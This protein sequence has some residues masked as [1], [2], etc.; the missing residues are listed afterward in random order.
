MLIRDL[1]ERDIFR[2]IN[3]VVKAEQLDD[4]SVWQELDEFVVT[5]ELDV[6]LRKFFSIYLDAIDQPHDASVGGKIGVW[7]SGFFGSGKSHF[8]KVLSY[9]LRNRTHQYD[10]Q[11]RQAVEFFAKKIK[12]AMF[13]GDI[14]R[15]VATPADV[16]LFNIESKADRRTDR[17]AI[18]QVFLK[19][20]NEMQGYSGDH[21][22][23]AHMERYLDGK[24]KLRQFQDAY[25]AATGSDWLQERDAYQF[26]RDEVAKALSETLGQSLQAAE[27]WIDGAED[28]FALTVE[29]F[30]K[31]V[32]AYL[33]SKE[34]SRRILFLVDE[35]GGF[36]GS[37]SGLMLSL[38][39]ITEDLGVI[40][41]G[42]A[43]VVVTSQEDIDAIL[44]EMK[45][46]KKNDFSKIQGR[47]KTRLSLS[48][49]NV[50]EVIQSR[51]LSKK[52]S[53][54]PEL[55]ALFTTKGDI[56]KHQLTFTNVGMTFRHYRDGEDFT[57]NYPF[58]PYQFQLVQKI[59]E[60]IRKAGA[61]GLHLAQG[62]RSLLDAFQLAGKQL[63]QH[64]V[65]ILVPLHRFYPSIESFLDNIVKRTIDQ[66]RD[67]ASLEPFDVLLL[68]VLFL[69]RYVDEMKANVD[70][71]V[72]LCTEKIDEDR[73]GLRR[74]IEE[75]LLRLEKETLISRSGD[76]YFFLTNEERDIGREIKNVELSGGEEA[77]VLGELI[78]DEVLKGQRKHRFSANK[79]DFTFNR[80]CD[81]H[82]V[83]NRADGALHVSV[84]TPLCD[85]YT[86]YDNAKCLLESTRENGHVL[87]RLSDDKNLG[88]ELRAYKKTDKYILTKNDGT[89][90]DSTGRIIKDLAADNRK[91][92]D[93]LIG[94]LSGMLVSAD[95]YVAGQPFKQKTSTP[96]AVLDEALHYLV[97]NTFGKMGYLL[98]LQAEPA[99]EIQAVLRTN[100]IGQ[101]TLA[102]TAPEGNPQAVDDVRAFIDLSTKAS[103]PIVL[104]ELIDGRYTRRPYGWPDMEV[105]LI[106]ARL[107]VLGEI[108]L[109]MDQTTIPLEKIYEAVNASSKWRKISILK[110]RTP[111]PKLLQDARVLGKDAFSEMGPDAENALSAFLR[112]KLDAW[113]ASLG[114]YRPLAE[115][116]EYP[117]KEEIT[118]GLTLLKKLLGDEESSKFIERFNSHKDDLLDLSEQF[119]ELEHFYGHQRATWEKLRKARERFQLN[120]LELERDP[121]AAQALSRMRDILAAK[122]PYSLLKEVDALVAT[123]T[124]VNAGLIA[125]RRKQALVQID[126]HIGALT[127]EL[128]AAKTDAAL[129]T[130]CL[131][132]LEKLRKRVEK[133]E[134]LAHISQSE[135]QS[136]GEFDA[137]LTFLE[138]A[139]RKAAEQPQE[140]PPPVIKKQCVIRPATLAGTGYL[141]NL[142]EVNGFLNTLRKEL[143][144]AIEKGERVQIR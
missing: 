64:E 140:D 2:S 29:N 93:G 48:S 143:E 78:F 75:S 35:V 106:L 50:D 54:K 103:R 127:K 80:F 6:H 72:T 121:Q 104:H 84:I 40:C 20:F 58:A 86:L 139:H 76:N 81:L 61:T 100:D 1:F 144:A 111:D 92:R 47:F 141:E 126:T 82:P 118:T 26:N 62:E 10:G 89:L 28:G 138:E 65:G 71:L 45:K 12:D 136:E 120:H 43:W 123:V 7:V 44:G 22:H 41:G 23:I 95:Y 85:D 31:W 79:M 8:I 91:R 21:P 77:R 4:S 112:G 38:Q 68:Q 83:G 97:E 59:F 110:R 87:C 107:L 69:I 32:K 15:A 114:G 105:V 36:I 33:D 18:L 133:E 137:A 55:Q 132:S 74:R 57:K 90:A 98:R 67:N 96:P 73:L 131:A 34:P 42:R 19:S 3:G 13:F 116:G 60:S 125:D 128:D 70:N 109:V 117:G 24:G 134:S 53:A 94:L 63:G 122:S 11:S 130:S 14:K 119:H 39:T 17:D 51:L 124:T 52:P 37:D 66:A 142:D 113:K 30:C 88:R 135:E 46:A 25:R 108:S 115:T 129:R 99:K 49:A 102:L 5:R 101:Q 27:K 56:V 16:I 9:L